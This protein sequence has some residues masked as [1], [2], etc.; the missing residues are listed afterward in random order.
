MAQLLL[1]E[2]TRQ[3]NV[4]AEHFFQD[5]DYSNW[6]PR[7][8]GDWLILLTL[9]GAGRVGDDRETWPL[10][11]GA[12][13]LFEQDAPQAYFTDPQAGFWEFLWA[14]FLPE[15]AWEDLTRWPLLRPGLRHRALASPASREGVAAALRE[16]V[17]WVQLGRPA[18]RRFARNALERALLWVDADGPEGSGHP[19]DSRI[20]EA[21]DQIGREVGRPFRLAE[22]A[23]H[24]GLSVS[25]LA[26]LFREQTG[27]TPLRYAEQRKFARAA[28]LL[29]LSSLRVE[30]VAGACGYGDPFHFAKRFRRWSGHSPTAYRRLNRG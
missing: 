8:S 21:L 25:R 14:H 11:P 3:S 5:R 17:R 1:R 30:E 13:A 19:P 16:V 9:Q 6:R 27:I 26:H 24:C 10:R 20:Q 15:P 7:G 23:R 4:Y 29:R 2:P 18:S 12:V 22:L 28:Q